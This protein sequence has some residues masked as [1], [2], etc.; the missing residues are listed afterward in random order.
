MQV[1]VI[2]T[3]NSNNAGYIY[4]L[5]PP[6]QYGTHTLVIHKRT[7]ACV[8]TVVDWFTRC[9]FYGLFV[10]GG[11]GHPGALVAAQPS[12]KRKPFIEFVGAK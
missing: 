9:T 5:C 2:Q 7:E 10:V 1:R 4:E 3:Y 6:Q 8:K 11:A 12:E